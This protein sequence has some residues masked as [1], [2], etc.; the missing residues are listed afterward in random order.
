[1]AAFQL[2]VKGCILIKS[3]KCSPLGLTLCTGTGMAAGLEVVS[4]FPELLTFVHGL[5]D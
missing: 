1:M 4:G 5:E 2:Q 3:E